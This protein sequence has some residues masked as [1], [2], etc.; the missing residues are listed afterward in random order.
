KDLS[1]VLGLLVGPEEEEGVAWRLELPSPR[2]GALREYRVAAW[3]DDPACPIDSEVRSRHEATVHALRQKGVTVDDH[4]R[5]G[6]QF[7]D[8]LG[9]YLRL[10]WA[11]MSPGLEL[12]QFQE[13]IEMSGQL[14]QDDDGYLAH[15]AHGAAQR[16]R[17]WL[18]WNEIRAQYRQKWKEFFT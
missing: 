13:F 14:P 6:F 4:A 2:R 11:A 3:L 10:L 16:H 15:F 12:E 1:L 8:A 5:P 9:A 18:F 7:A 17:D